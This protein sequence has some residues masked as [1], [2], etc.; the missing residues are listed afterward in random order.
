MVLPIINSSMT[1]LG[2]NASFTDTSPEPKMTAGPNPPAGVRK[3]QKAICPM[4]TVVTSGDSPMAARSG[5]KIAAPKD[6]SA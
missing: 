2:R 4:A 6:A 3:A 1:T 5:V